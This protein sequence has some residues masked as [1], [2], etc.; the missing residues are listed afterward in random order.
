MK[1][2][3]KLPEECA[4]NLSFSVLT[5][6]GFCF[7][8]CKFLHTLLTI[9][10]ILV[11]T[12]ILQSFCNAQAGGRYNNWYFGYNSALTWNNGG[13]PV[14]LNNSGMHTEE[15][16]ATISD[17]NGNLLF[18]TNGMKVWNS[19]HQVIASGLMGGA[20]SAQAA[21]IIP[22]PLNPGIYYILTTPDWGGIWSDGFIYYREVTVDGTIVTVEPDNHLIYGQAKVSE[23]ITATCTGNENELWVISHEAHTDAFIFIKVTSAGPVF[24]HLQHIGIVHDPSWY[25]SPGQIKVSHNG[26]KLGIANYYGRRFEVYDFDKTNGLLSNLRFIQ[27]ASIVPWGVEFS[28]DVQKVYIANDPA[29]TALQQYVI[30]PTYLE[31]TY[32]ANLQGSLGLR[33]LQLQ[34]DGKIYA[35]TASDHVDIVNN[36]NGI[37]DDCNFVSPGIQIQY[38]PGR[39]GWTP[40]GLAN[41]PWIWCDASLE[42]TASVTNVSCFGGSTG[43]VDI[44]VT[45]GN[46]PLTYSYSWSNSATTQDLVNIPAGTYTVTVT[47]ASGLTSAASYTVTEPQQL[48]INAS[49]D[50]LVYYGYRQANCA[51]LSWSGA[52]GGVEPYNIV[53]STAQ[54]AQTIIV[55]PTVTTTYSVTITDANN[56]TFS[57]QVKV[58]VADIRCGNKNDPWKKVNLCHFPNGNQNNPQ[59]LC[60]D[61]S[62]VQDHLTNHPGDHLG[63]CGLSCDELKSVA[64]GINNSQEPDGILFDAYPNPFS[65]IATITFTCPAEGYVTINLVDY[66]G[67]EAVLLFGQ[68]VKKEVQ[69]QVQVAGDRLSQGMYFSILQHSDGTMKVKKLIYTK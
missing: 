27:D 42:I 4:K 13:V 26:T 67:K 37:G 28:P 11:F 65:G 44:T 36:P 20:S 50:Q 3:K 47:D 69:Y 10:S 34:T 53:W 2:I 54:T 61:T 59:N 51:T 6:T 35:N 55:C 30:H 29:G 43:A 31:L 38:V 49:V 63:L 21:L 40:S 23:K 60:I 14:S 8:R 15:G 68:N 62:A 56:C 45:G 48:T 58:C 22:K 24:D 57:D 9:A 46:F 41:N 16:C 52:S 39:P 25:T 1:F 12:I 18:Y 66:T 32:N 7:Q 5:G 64:T 17:I 33:T 19:S